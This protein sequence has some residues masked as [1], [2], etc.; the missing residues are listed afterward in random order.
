M[1]RAFAQLSEVPRD[2]ECNTSDEKGFV[3]GLVVRQWMAVISALLRII[4]GGPSASG[5]EYV[6]I[7]FKVPLLACVTR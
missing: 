5:K 4:Q 3:D 6:D 2:K 7:K 1:T